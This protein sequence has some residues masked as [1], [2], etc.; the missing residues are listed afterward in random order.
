MSGKL[1]TILI[2]SPREE[3]RDKGKFNEVIAIKSL[4]V[5]VTSQDKLRR[6]DLQQSS[7][8]CLSLFHCSFKIFFICCLLEDVFKTLAY[9]SARFQDINRIMMF[10]LADTPQKVDNYNTL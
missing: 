1:Q 5:L 3:L 6:G 2:E 9:V 7:Y 4:A 10:F 8:F